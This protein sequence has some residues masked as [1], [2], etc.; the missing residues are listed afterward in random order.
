MTSKG[1]SK[2]LLIAASSA[3]LLA[4]TP[5]FRVATRLIQVNVIVT[6]HHGDPVTGL[7]KDDFVISDQGHPQKIV[8]FNEQTGR[9][10]PSAPAASAKQGTLVFSNRPD[11]NAGTSSGSATVVLFDRLNTTF[12]DSAFA[13]ARLAQFLSGVRAE[14]RF[15]LYGLSS[16]LVILQ[17]LTQDASALLRALKGYKPV[18]TAETRATTIKE[19]NSGFPIIDW[20]ENKAN[21]DESDARMVD[22]AHATAVALET[23]ANHLAGLPGRKNLVWVSAAFPIT[24]GYTLKP[25]RGI[26]GQQ[27][28]ATTPVKQSYDAEVEAAARALSNANIAIYPV[29]AHVLGTLGGVFDASKAPKPGILMRESNIPL[30]EMMSTAELGTMTTLADAT[31]GRVFANTNDI[32]G[33]VRRAIDDSAFTYTLGYYPDHDHW[34]GKFREIKVKVD[35]AG[36]EVRNRSGYLAAA[37]AAPTAAP[38]TVAEV[39]RRPLESSELGLSVETE[40]LGE[41]QF[42]LHVRIDTSAMHLE[43]KDG[44]WVGALEVLWVQLGAD[45]RDVIGHGQTLNFRLSPETYAGLPR[46]GLKI[47]SVETIE[48]KAVQL[49]FAARDAG[50]GAVGSLYIPVPRLSEH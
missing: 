50:T 33:A 7:K 37:D 10:Q 20:F 35:R 39:I 19:V 31:G 2:G 14:D 17:D 46:D 42:K 22:R 41:R 18:E 8:F 30:P 49:R 12:E 3:I 23:I 13:R 34:D 24:I 11:E 44:R 29:D 47:S 1:T 9:S 15:A 16:R 21:Q 6:D 28:L 45:G 40:R 43:Q 5:S 25:V 36:V 32:A 27:R 38:A 48:E 4:Q 26:L